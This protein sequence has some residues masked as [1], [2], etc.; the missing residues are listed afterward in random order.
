MARIAYTGTHP[1]GMTFGG[2]FDSD[3]AEV[4]EG[5]DPDPDGYAMGEELFLS[6]AAWI[7]NRVTAGNPDRSTYELIEADEAREWLE[8]N[9]HPEA[10]K[11]YFKNAKGGRPS[12]GERLVTRVPA[13]THNRI[14]A[15]SELYAEDMPDTVRRLLDEALSHRETI[16]APG[17][18]DADVRPY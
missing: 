6:G 18:R 16:G 12:I 9:H 5:N 17:S 4:F 11:R 14:A 1:D 10:V 8:E 2:L 15:L 13:R 3:T 7:L